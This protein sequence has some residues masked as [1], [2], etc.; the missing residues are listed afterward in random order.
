MKA[1]EKVFD[2]F[3]KAVSK[4]NELSPA[5]LA[6]STMAYFNLAANDMD[7]L[8]REGIFDLIE[9]IKSLDKNA[10]MPPAQLQIYE[11]LPDIVEVWAVA[12]MQHEHEQL[13]LQAKWWATPNKAYL[14][15][16]NSRTLV[17]GIARKENVSFAFI[18]NKKLG[19][20]VDPLHVTIL[21]AVPVSNGR[22]ADERFEENLFR[23][24][25]SLAPNDDELVDLFKK[26]S[27]SLGSTVKINLNS[28]LD[29]LANVCSEDFMSL[30]RLLLYL[31]DLKGSGL[32]EKEITI[33]RRNLLEFALV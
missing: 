31:N 6:C 11:A 7:D 29:E 26:V 14:N 21:S 25:A 18:E 15:S 2:C 10:M 3:F 8:E 9:H 30:T 12:D 20:A 19:I 23:D 13:T 5:E 32:L 1:D 27:T 16:D 28:T 33:T 24:G 17:H 4:K 22:C